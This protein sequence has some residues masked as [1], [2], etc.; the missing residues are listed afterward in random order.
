[1]KKFLTIL[2]AVVALAGSARSQFVVSAHLGGSYTKAGGSWALEHH[3]FDSLNTV[4]DTTAAYSNP[5]PINLTG[6]LK[7]GYQVRRLQFGI[8]GS[9]SWGQVDGNMT[10]YDYA[11]QNQAFDT[12]LYTNRFVGKYHQTMKSYS[13]APYVRFE[14]IQF[15]DVALFLE[16]N[17]YYAAAFKPHRRDTVDWYYR[18]MHNTIDTSYDV[19][20]TSNAFGAKLVPGMTWQLSPHCHVELYLD[21]LAFAFDRTI[22]KET[23]VVDEFD[24]FE[25]GTRRVS[26]RTTTTSTTTSDYMGFGITGTPLLTNRNWVRVGF[27]FTF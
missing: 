8:S 2:S 18:D 4:F 11:K 25:E 1:M 19:E 21:F 14:C 7:F 12:N 20:H 3:T 5:I 24:T 22:E 26:R 10:V 23:T 9:F 16:L 17:G 15:G 13:V 6:G 27:S